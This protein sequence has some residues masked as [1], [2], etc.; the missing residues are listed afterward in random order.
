MI[1]LLPLWNILAFGK[2]ININ[3]LI[4]LL[5]SEEEVVIIIVKVLLVHIWTAGRELIQVVLGLLRLESLLN[6]WK[7]VLRGLA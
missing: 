7:G 3:I 5:N 2:L 1:S 4:R 6:V